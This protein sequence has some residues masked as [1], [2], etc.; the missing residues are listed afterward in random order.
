MKIKPK[1][2]GRAEI[3]L[4]AG[5]RNFL[6]WL[7]VEL[8]DLVFPYDDTMSEYEYTLRLF[9][10]VDGIHRPQNPV[11]MR[12][13]PDIDPE[14]EER[15]ADFRSSNEFELRRMKANTLV[16]IAEKI[17][18]GS[19]LTLEKSEV[20]TWVAGLADLRLFVATYLDEDLEE[21]IRMAEVT[22]W[23]DRHGYDVEQF[24][25]ILDVLYETLGWM[26][27]VLTEILLAPLYEAENS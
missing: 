20:D 26:Q 15:S 25:Y 4:D 2:G 27:E 19:S 6:R 16:S 9:G 10:M 1:G 17:H 7:C 5:E 12:L 22:D 8:S 23:A 14:D 13:L 24:M 21:D 11:L 3:M 18:D